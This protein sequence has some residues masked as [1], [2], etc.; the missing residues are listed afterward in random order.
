MIDI[1]PFVTMCWNTRELKDEWEPILADINSVDY[2]AQYEMIK[3]GH[4]EANTY[5]YGTHNF[6]N[7]INWVSENGFVSLNIHR[8]QSHQGYDH[9]FYMKDNIDMNT[10]IYGGVAL[11]YDTVLKFKEAHLTDHGTDHK[12]V[13]QMLGYPDCCID[14]FL[15]NWIG[16]DGVADPSWRCAA[17]TTGSRVI[18]NVVGVKGDARLNNLLRAFGFK[19]GGY[20]THSYD[21]PEAIVFADKWVEC[22]REV[23]PES[24][25]KLLELLD[26][27]MSWSLYNGII[28]VKTPVFRGAT[29]GY[30]TEDKFTV[31]WNQ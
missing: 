8:T 1:F 28:E 24:T 21:C 14:W 18:D 15:E 19:V 5:H 12:L 26:M 7:Q 22:M 17:N 3:K 25:D 6:D 2:Y 16:E 27:P 13:G 29:N 9:K 23:K 20:F 4:R 10:T 31:L 30:Y 11:D